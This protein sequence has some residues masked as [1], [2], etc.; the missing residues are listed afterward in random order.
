M[1]YKCED[2]CQVSQR[3]TLP[4]MACPHIT[5]GGRSGT[6]I[7]TNPT[8]STG[9]RP[10]RMDLRLNR[11]LT[12]QRPITDFSCHELGQAHGYLARAAHIKN[13]ASK[14]F[15]FWC[16]DL[17]WVVRQRSLLPATKRERESS[18]GS[19]RGARIRHFCLRALWSWPVGGPL[20]ETCL[21][22]EKEIS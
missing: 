2:D 10:S 16:R 5:G 22:R 4:H 12:A 19:A 7:P 11:E 21:R 20:L 6:R 3:K 14:P 9:H 8:R 17:Y 18:L 13:R 1:G 15:S